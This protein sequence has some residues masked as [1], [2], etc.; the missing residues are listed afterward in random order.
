MKLSKLIKICDP[1]SPGYSKLIKVS[2]NRLKK[3]NI[4]EIRENYDRLFNEVLRTTT[5]NYLQLLAKPNSYKTK[6]T[7]VN[8]VLR[9]LH[10]D[11][12][13]TD[14]KGRIRVHDTW[15]EFVNASN[16][17]DIVDTRI[18]YLETFFNKYRDV[19]IS[20]IYTSNLTMGNGSDVI[21]ELQQFVGLYTSPRNMVSEVLKEQNIELNIPDDYYAS[22]Q[23]IQTV[24]RCDFVI[25]TRILE[26]TLSHF[27]L[28]LY[29]TFTDIANLAVIFENGVSAFSIGKTGIN[30]LIAPRMECRRTEGGNY[31]LHSTEN[32]SYSSGDVPDLYFINGVWVPKKYWKMATDKTITFEKWIKISNM[33]QRRVVIEEGGAEC[34][35]SHPNAVH[36]K[37][38]P[39]GNKLITIKN[40]TKATNQ[41]PALDIKI[42]QYKDPSTTRLYNSFVPAR[43]PNDKNTTRFDE[44]NSYELTDPDE[45]MAWKFGKTKDE[46]YGELVAEA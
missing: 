20:N 32:H 9:R 14:H 46:Y 24:W 6:T 29:N 18:D 16:K 39:H 12:H 42:L 4:V 40:A 38:S 2:N 34:F 31:Q 30:V 13:S 33:E 3:G 44:T 5:A 25:A 11:V 10:N 27:K 41:T 45:A 37:V 43:I 8:K 21:K 28:K 17:A 26:K 19:F 35:A 7:T 15:S 22:K 1:K 36:S 23:Q